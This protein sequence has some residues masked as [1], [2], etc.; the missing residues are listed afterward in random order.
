MQL[1]RIHQHAK[2]CWDTISTNVTLRGTCF[3]QQTS[4]AFSLRLLP[5]RLHEA[6]SYSKEVPLTCSSQRLLPADQCVLGRQTEVFVNHTPQVDGGIT[7]H[8]LTAVHGNERFGCS[9][10]GPL[11]SGL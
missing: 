2:S 9:T 11:V 3:W 5:G 7:K 4:T 1:F 8:S 10:Q 6:S